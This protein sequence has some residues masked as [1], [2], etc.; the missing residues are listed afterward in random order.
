[1]LNLAHFGTW[2]L[3]ILGSVHILSSGPQ[4][5]TS[6]AIAF[7]L[8]QWFA[9]SAAK[10]SGGAGTSHINHLHRSTRVPGMLH[11]LQQ[12]CQATPVHPIITCIG[13]LE[14][15]VWCSKLESLLFILEKISPWSIRVHHGKL[16]CFRRLTVRATC[17]TRN[18]FLKKK[19]YAF[20]EI[21]IL[22]CFVTVFYEG[23]TAVW[24]G[25]GWK[26]LIFCPRFQFLVSSSHAV[27]IFSKSARDSSLIMRF[28]DSWLH[29]A[30]G[31]YRVG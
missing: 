18:F 6:S 25:F 26:M 11:D 5:P 15:P 13:V 3:L 2:I 22:S 30:S 19:R 10:L 9:W 27:A 23:S 1:M 8:F 28:L 16:G 21:D 24:R 20:R 31:A 12:N 17:S 29:A 14:Y 7:V 4:F